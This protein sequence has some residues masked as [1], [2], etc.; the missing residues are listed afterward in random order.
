MAG[1]RVDGLSRE[2][3]SDQ[4]QEY[5]DVSEHGN[6]SEL[7]ES[8]G[9]SVD[10]DYTSSSG[11][12]EADG[13]AS[14]DSEVVGSHRLRRRP[15]SPKVVT[16]AHRRVPSPARS[17]TPERGIPPP[18]ARGVAPVHPAVTPVPSVT[19]DRGV[20]P[21]AEHDSPIDLTPAR[22]LDLTPL[23]NPGITAG[24]FY[25]QGVQYHPS[26]F[27]DEGEQD[28]LF[29]TCEEAM[30]PNRDFYKT[31]QSELV[32][33]AQPSPQPAP[34]Q[35][36]YQ[37]A[38]ELPVVSETDY[39]PPQDSTYTVLGPP[40]DQDLVSQIL[41]DIDSYGPQP[42]PALSSY[43][44]VPDTPDQSP[45]P[46]NFSSHHRQ[47]A[48]DQTPANIRPQDQPPRSPTPD[49][50]S[51]TWCSVFQDGSRTSDTDF[52]PIEYTPENTA[53]PAPPACARVAKRKLDISDPYGPNASRPARIP[54]SDPDRGRQPV[55][56]RFSDF[57]HPAS[58]TFSDNVQPGA[59]HVVTPPS[60]VVPAQVLRDYTPMNVGRTRHSVPT[61]GFKNQ[62]T[63][64]PV[65]APVP[66]VVAPAPPVV[67]PAPPVVAPAPPVVTPASS[68]PPVVAA[69]VSS[70]T[71]GRPPKRG[72]RGS[73]GKK[74]I[75]FLKYIFSF[76]IL[77]ICLFVIYIVFS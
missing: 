46:S 47:P 22:P 35:E 29:R 73:Q 26:S 56:I 40:I 69:R 28:E 68:A 15:R 43:T 44:V 57:V 17:V 31:A 18:P 66:P 37:T 50:Y 72:R 23:R 45:V 55:E 27:D 33:P 36:L 53:T 39:V 3:I 41:R 2:E 5:D 61:G 52:M 24:T 11:G 19:P 16:P 13:N 12:E 75:Y 7:N 21:P 6:I 77:F 49:A 74:S 71:R 25:P 67:A 58:I 48:R 54:S 20:A 34:V 1:R 70:K 62:Y 51:A 10:S 65:V 30:F 60:L 76:N 4:L 63:R 42:S 64:R 32:L 59:G 38:R 9:W 8:D 14:S